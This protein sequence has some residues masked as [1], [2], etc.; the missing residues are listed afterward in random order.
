MN[1]IASYKAFEKALALLASGEIGPL[2]E[3]VHDH[4]RLETLLYAFTTRKEQ[5]GRESEL[6]AYVREAS[7]KG[8]EARQSNR[9]KLC[10]EREI[11][12]AREANRRPY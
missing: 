12:R 11:E 1:R 9:A 5:S 6:K 7:E 10:R 2:G 8:F 4:R 3:E